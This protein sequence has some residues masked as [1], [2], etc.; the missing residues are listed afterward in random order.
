MSLIVGD[1]VQLMMYKNSNYSGTTVM[2]DQGAYVECLPSTFSD[3]MSSFT[4]YSYDPPSNCVNLFSDCYYQG[5][6]SQYCGSNKSLPG[7]ASSVKVGSS[8]KNAIL[9]S[10]TNYSG[11]SLTLSTQN[12]GY[13]SDSQLNFNDMTKS[14][15]VVP[16]TADGCVTLYSDCY[17]NTPSTTYCSS[18]TSLDHNDYYSSLVV[19][20][21][22]QV[23]LFQNSNYGGNRVSFGT[24]NGIY[25]VNCLNTYNFNDEVSSLKIINGTANSGCVLTYQDCNYGG[26]AVEYC[27]S[28]SSTVSGISSIKVGLVAAAVFYDTSNYKNNYISLTSQSN[29]PC[30]VNNNFNDKAASVAIA[31]YPGDG[32]MTLWS[33]CW[34]GGDSITYCSS[35]SQLAKNDY[36]SSLAVGAN[37]S[38][39]VYKDG[40]YSGS[41]YTFNA[42][43]YS[44]CLTSINMN[45]ALSSVKLN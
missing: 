36:Y 9:Y 43:T 21:N 2:Y 31:Y 11:N 3:V 20:A 7:T 4:L 34:F 40:K 8:V 28:S 6:V 29:Y 42:N 26:E 32:C 37:H 45:D 25:N 5:V 44:I 16:Y 19:G 12:Y 22:I 33:D 17:Y 38:W 10:S 35:Q 39:T 1:G 18:T 13:L 30:L 24:N 23:S 41:S 27:G 15:V 14:I